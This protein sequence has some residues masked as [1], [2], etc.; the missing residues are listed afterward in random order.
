M[1]GLTGE[2]LCHFSFIYNLELSV[3]RFV[4]NTSQT[5][6]YPRRYLLH[7]LTSVFTPRSSEFTN[8]K[9]VR[10]RHCD[11]MKPVTFN[12]PWTAEEQV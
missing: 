1:Q 7:S 10:G 6:T 9:L 3:E 8:G 4:Q 5:I 2:L 11:E 12:Q